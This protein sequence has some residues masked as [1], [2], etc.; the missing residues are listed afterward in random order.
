MKEMKSNYY[1]IFAGVVTAA[2][3]AFGALLFHDE[4]S[5]PSLPTWYRTT[6]N[7]SDFDDTWS[8]T[9]R[10]E[11]VLGNSC[12]CF[13]IA[14]PTLSTNTS[15]RWHAGLSTTLL[16]SSVL[17]YVWELTFDIFVESSEP[18]RI[19]ISQTGL[20]PSVPSVEQLSTYWVTPP[21]AGWQQITINSENEAIISYAMGLPSE[22]NRS[23][24]LR[25]GL[26]SHD[27]AGLPLSISEIGTYTF[28]I[29]NLALKSSD[30]AYVALK[31]W[32]TGDT[33]L[34]FSG[35]LQS[36]GDLNAWTTIEPQPSSPFVIPLDMEKVFFRA[37]TE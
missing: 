32:S 36:S 31:T 9:S 10:L 30:A 19:S 33:S 6:I 21:E 25:I 14:I 22:T 28:K 17:P 35:T 20:V 29:D 12:A 26:S 4:F 1:I 16:Q 27:G 37:F 23:S 2:Y 34:F 3:S 15:E 13:D 11:T 8:V 5:A 18:V 7:P 24:T